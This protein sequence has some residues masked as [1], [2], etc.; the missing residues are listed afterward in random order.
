MQKAI[1]VRSGGKGGL[2]ELNTYLDKGWKVV[3]SQHDGCSSAIVVIIEREGEQNG[4]L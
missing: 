1:L 2:D 4:V 3:H